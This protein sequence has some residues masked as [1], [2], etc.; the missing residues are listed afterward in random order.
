MM[1]VKS[2]AGE[3]KRHHETM[4]QVLSLPEMFFWGGGFAVK[5]GVETLVFFWE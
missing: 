3:A 5:R 4:R 2:R 1:T